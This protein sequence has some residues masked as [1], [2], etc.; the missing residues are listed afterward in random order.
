MLRWTIVLAAVGIYVLVVGCV[1]W[2][3]DVSAQ[4]GT[5][6]SA[7]QTAPVITS[8]EGLPLCSVTMQIQR[9][10]WIDKYIKGIDE[11]TALGADGVKF[12]VDTRQETVSSTRIFLDMRMTPT[13][14]QLGSLIKHAKSKNL[15]VILMPIV[16][17]DNPQGMDWRGKIEP[18]TKYGGWDE[19]FSSYRN[20]LTHFAW[21]AQTHGADIFV[22]GSEFISAEPKLD[23]WSKTIRQVRDTFKGRLTY[24]S[25]WDHYESVKFWDQLDLICM[26]SYWKFADEKAPNPSV[27]DIKKRWVAIQKDLIPWVQKQGKPLLFSEIGWFSQKNVA[28]EPWD[29]TRDQD[30]DLDLQRKLYQAFFESWWGNADLGGFSVWEWPPAEGGPKD[31]GYTPKGKPAEGVIKEWFGKPR[32]RVR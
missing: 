21:I 24:S 8:R 19:W 31:K 12:V 30:L 22:V 1:L 25:N 2:Q 17:L 13:P 26:N 28:Y 14:D 15:K 23:Q 3:S 5:R 9:T 29:Y 4:P 7:P 11:I 16:L 27:E 18:D 6:T 10:D 20:M 32:W